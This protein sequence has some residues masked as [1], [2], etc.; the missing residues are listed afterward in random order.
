M[1][2]RGFSEILRSLWLQ[3]KIDKEITEEFLT[4][5][6][7]S[8]H[9]TLLA[10]VIVTLQASKASANQLDLPPEIIENSPVFQKWQKEIPNVLEDIDN[11]PSFPT[12]L[13]LGYSVFPS[14]DHIDGINFGVEDIFLGRSGLSISAGYQTSFNGDR[15]TVGGDLQYYFFSLGSYINFG[16]VVGY[17]YLQTDDYH[18]QGVNVG[19]RLVIALS[20]G[21]GADITIT[22]SFVSPGSEQEVGITNLSFGYALTNNLR[23]STDIQQQN[24]PRANDSRVG[25]VLEFLP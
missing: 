15:L 7:R 25:I 19:A 23:L 9:L 20:R 3:A 11:D 1:Y 2:I 18:T 6:R 13:R 4:L 14:N 17:R 24:S 5:K 12:R 8:H 21:G 10:M 16:P 22:Q